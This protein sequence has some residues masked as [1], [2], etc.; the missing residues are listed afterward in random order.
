MDIL[1]QIQNYKPINDQE[2]KDKEVFLKYLN[3][4]DN[5]LERENEYGHMCSSAFVL[6]KERTKILMIHHNIYNSWGWLGGHCDGDS[7]FLHV[8]IKEVKEESGLEQ[9]TPLSEEIFTLDTLPVLG[10]TKRGKYVP[11]HV[12]LSV[13]YL[14]EADE[15]QEIHIQEEENSG[16]K[17]I[18]IKEMVALADEPYMKPVYAKAIEKMKTLKYIK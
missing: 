14:L 3:T 5:Y 12:H 10:H 1:E 7:D 15:N 2:K 13:A 4:F 6:N 8:A 18:P 17:W 11:A 16:V 9:V